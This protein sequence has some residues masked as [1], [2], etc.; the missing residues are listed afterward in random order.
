MRRANVNEFKDIEDM[1]DKFRE[2]LPCQSEIPFPPIKVEKQN[3]EYANMLLDAYSSS[4]DSELQAITQYIYHSKTISNKTISN[5]L[6]CIALVEM[7]HLDALSELIP[8]LGGK[9]FYLNSN[10]NFWMTGNIAYVDK[11]VI[12]KKEHDNAKEDN[13]KTKQ[14]LE[15]NLASEINAINGYKIIL[16]NI[17]DVYLEKIIHKI[18]SDEQVHKK[19]LEDLIKR[20]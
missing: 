10:Q 1:I 15:K 18:V 3:I 16:Q 8:L 4:A 2:S 13:E 7:G 14:K 11:N 19:L 17:S 20:Y 12:Y 9:P 6:M 5:A